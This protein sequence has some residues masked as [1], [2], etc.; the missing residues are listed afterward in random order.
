MI[1]VID[2]PTLRSKLKIGEPIGFFDKPANTLCDVAKK[3]K[4]LTIEVVYND[5]HAD[6]KSVIDV[7]SL[8]IHCDQEFEIWVQGEDGE[9][10][11]EALEDIVNK[12]T[13]TYLIDEV[14][15]G[16]TIIEDEI[17]ATYKYLKR[18]ELS[19]QISILKGV[20]V[21]L[22]ELEGYDYRDYVDN[23]VL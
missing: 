1:E 4:D 20:C 10:V 12:L 6:A 14:D 19:E 13:D 23:L 3:Y 18:F 11:E 2:K 22:A 9:K 5:K 21:K 8:A 7:L 16:E 17:Q 15:M